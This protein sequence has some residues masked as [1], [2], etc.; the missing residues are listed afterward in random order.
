MRAR[1]GG[2]RAA[3]DQIK[4]TLV[5]KS[6]EIDMDRQTRYGEKDSEKVKTSNGFYDADARLMTGW[7]Q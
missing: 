6:S 1:G 3:L 2:R 5:Y 7:Y 4:E